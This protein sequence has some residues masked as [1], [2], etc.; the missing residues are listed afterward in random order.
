[1][2]I[3]SF[4]KFDCFHVLFPEVQDSEIREFAYHLKKIIGNDLSIIRRATN[5]NKKRLYKNK[6]IQYIEIKNTI[7]GLYGLLLCLFKFDEL[8]EVRGIKHFHKFEL[9]KEIRDLHNTYYEDVKDFYVKFKKDSPIQNLK[10]NELNSNILI[11]IK[12]LIKLYKVK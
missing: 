6:D 3:E 11:K 12:N 1:M 10:T 8:I 7:K 4:L 9:P 5:D 2:S